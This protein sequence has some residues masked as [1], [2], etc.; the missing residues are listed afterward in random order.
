MMSAVNSFFSETEVAN[1]T[2]CKLLKSVGMEIESKIEK[3]GAS[4]YVFIILK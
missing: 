2:S 3:Y 4:Q 1:V